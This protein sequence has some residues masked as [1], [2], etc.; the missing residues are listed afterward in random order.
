MGFFSL[1]IIFLLRHLKN[2]SILKVEAAPAQTSIMFKHICTRESSAVD[3]R[4]LNKMQI[5]SGL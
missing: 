3:Y 5:I 2:Q 1:L 4:F